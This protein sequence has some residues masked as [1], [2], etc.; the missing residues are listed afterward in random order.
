MKKISVKL[1]TQKDKGEL[2]KFFEHYGNKTLSKNRVEYYLSHNHTVVAK[3]G[4]KI[5][6]IAQ[7]YIK[8]DPKTGVAEVEEVY[9]LDEYRDQG[10]GHKIIKFTINS[11]KNNFNKI[12]FK[13]RK[14][15]LFV[16]KNN[17]P[18]ITLYQKVGFQEI[19]PVGNLFDDS[20]TELFYCL[21][22]K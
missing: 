17:S 11:I 9:V 15:Y 4:N 5:V 10:I 12:G 2:L 14:V 6:G 8:E 16:N 21:N 19:N 3:D 18:A 1:A 7:W 20:E 22:L 13:P